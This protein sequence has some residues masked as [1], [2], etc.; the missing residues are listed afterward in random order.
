ML[1]FKRKGQYTSELDKRGMGPTS[2]RINQWEMKRTFFICR[3]LSTC[4]ADTFLAKKSVCGVHLTC[5]PTRMLTLSFFYFTLLGSCSDGN[6]KLK[7][8]SLIYQKNKK[9]DI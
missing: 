1:Y 6:F 8:G 2:K 3:L 9:V 4:D 5:E 7:I